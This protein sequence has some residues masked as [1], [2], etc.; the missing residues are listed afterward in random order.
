[1]PVPTTP[2]ASRPTAL[3]LAALLLAPPL[4]AQQAT[5][6]EAPRITPPDGAPAQRMIEDG[7][8]LMLRGILTELAPQL[9]EMGRDMGLVMGLLGPAVSDLSRLMDDVANYDLPERLPNGDIVI[10]RKPGAPPPPAISEGLQ[11]FLPYG[12]DRVP[13]P[14]PWSD[15]RPGERGIAPTGPQT[16]L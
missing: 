15:A 13:R 2:V 4:A 16:D 1:M 14:S 9:D 12:M 5:P 7:A 3:A 6:F 11:G 10:R 8:Q